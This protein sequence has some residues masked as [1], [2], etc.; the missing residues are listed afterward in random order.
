ME[1]GVPSGLDFPVASEIVA[2]LCVYVDDLLLSAGEEVHA[3]IMDQLRETWKTSEP[4][5]PYISDMLD[6]YNSLVP[7][8]T[9]KQPGT[10]ESYADSMQSTAGRVTESQIAEMRA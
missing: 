7:L 9:C 6:K 3:Q 4:K 8:K 5:I 2:F 10:P 1:N